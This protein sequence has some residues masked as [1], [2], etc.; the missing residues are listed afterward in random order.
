M[1]YTI[2]YMVV[3]I[4]ESSNYIAWMM[5]NI[6]TLPTTKS[7]LASVASAIEDVEGGRSIYRHPGF[8]CM[9]RG[10]GFAL[11]GVTSPNHAGVYSRLLD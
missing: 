2:T 11:G 7:Y 5:K 1:L 4:R 10:V 6:N 8:L 3:D 9:S